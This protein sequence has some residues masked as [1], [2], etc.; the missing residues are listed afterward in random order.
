LTT[1]Q[2]TECYICSLNELDAK[3]TCLARPCDSTRVPVT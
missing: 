3:G 1:T 2:N